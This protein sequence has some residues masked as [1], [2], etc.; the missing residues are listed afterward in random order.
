MEREK[1]VKVLGIDIEK[2]EEKLI[3]LGAVKISEENQKNILIESDSTASIPEGSY[4]RIREIPS[5]D[6]EKSVI[7]FKKN[8]ENDNLRENLEFTSEILDTENMLK[9][10]K[11]IGYGNYSIGY[12]YRISYIYENCRFDLDR[13]D[14]ET[15]PYP[16]AEI[17]LR[18]EVDL[19]KILQKLEIDKSCISKKSIKELQ[20]ELNRK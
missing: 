3:N 13:W 18:D 16:Y 19:D 15:Y 12:K 1:E 7:T 9:I 4:L 10:L 6:E 11:E 5:A 2:L 17:E 8:I 20:D 14:E